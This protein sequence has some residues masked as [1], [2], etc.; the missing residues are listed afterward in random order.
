[1]KFDKPV[2]KGT[3]L[4]R[5]K[6]FLTDIELAEDHNG[7]KIGEIITAHTANTGSMKT[8]VAEGWPVLL[9]FNDSPTRKLKYSLELTYNGKTWIGVNTAVPNKI[10]LEAI[11]NGTISQLQDYEN[12]KPEAKIGESR[13]DIYLF[14]GD[15]KTPTNECYVEVKNVSMIEGTTAVF[16]DAVSE[17]GQ[18]HL[19]E[20]IS[21][22]EKGIRACM[23]YIIQ[24]EDVESFAPA[25]SIDPEYARLLKLAYDKGVEILPYRCKVNERGVEVDKL[26]P[27]QL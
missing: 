27:F 1:M 22:K 20:L 11:N 16:P 3:F 25:K 6:R 26:L 14:D 2:V 21:L 10:S 4:K 24:R 19:R 5:Y 8:C 18:K 23:L 13:I 12:I 17:R 15:K 7:N 9:S